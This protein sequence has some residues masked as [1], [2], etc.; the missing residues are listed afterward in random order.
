MINKSS[1]EVSA[2]LLAADY[3]NMARDVARA[4]Q[5]GV[6]SFHFDVMDG[7]YVPNIALSPHH[8]TALRPYSSLPFSLHLELGN[9]DQVLDM[10]GELDADIIAFQWDR[11]PDPDATI[12][13]ICARQVEISVCVN[14]EVALEDIKP[15]ISKVDE[16]LLLG[17]HPGFGG[18]SMD[19]N[20][21]DRVFQMKKMIDQEKPGVPIAID[22]GVSL[23]T[24][25]TL[26]SAGATRLITGSAIFGASDMAEFVRQM[27]AVN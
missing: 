24:A 23:Q 19:E 2:S 4:V 5:A 21:G 18:Q 7:H 22:G 25:A 14:L 8:L 15:Y 9:P 1:I 27:K 20:M 6:D 12:K 16:I 11:S 26:V 3:A 13:R 17:V 10:F